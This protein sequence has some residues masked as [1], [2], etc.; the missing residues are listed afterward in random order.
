[1]QL[2]D[3]HRHNGPILNPVN[4]KVSDH[5]I[6]D[7]DDL[8]KKSSPGVVRKPKSIPDNDILIHNL[9]IPPRHIKHPTNFLLTLQRVSAR[10]IQLIV[11]VLGDP[12]MMFGEQRA[13]FLDT[14]GSSE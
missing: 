9:L 4:T 3:L 2:K 13:L 12:Y 1:M 7:H 6:P 8:K 14:T 10:R 5:S 11:A